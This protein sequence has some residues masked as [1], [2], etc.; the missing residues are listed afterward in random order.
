MQ[1]E[2]AL[3]IEMLE[4]KSSILTQYYSATPKPILMYVVINVT[5]K[6]NSIALHSPLERSSLLTL[7][8]FRC[9]C[10]GE[11]LSMQGQGMVG[12]STGGQCWAA[13]LSSSMGG[14]WRD[15]CFPAALHPSPVLVTLVCGRWSWCSIL[16]W[17]APTRGASQPVSVSQRLNKGAHKEWSSYSLVCSFPPQ[18]HADYRNKNI[19]WRRKLFLDANQD[20]LDLGW[21]LTAVSLRSRWNIFWGKKRII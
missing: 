15:A 8:Q 6:E 7:W 9:R 16:I 18:L 17:V 12:S 20:S 21:L 3:N 5:L 11:Q 14:L 19:L 4:L 13:L 10:P 1:K 2:A